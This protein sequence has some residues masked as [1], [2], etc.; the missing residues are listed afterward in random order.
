MLLDTTTTPELEA[1]GLARDVIRAVQDTRKA[2]GFDV[3]DRIRLRLLFQNADDGHAVQSA[4]EAADVAGETL[5][6]DARVLIAGELD[7]ADAGGVNTFSAVAARGH[8][9]NVAKGTYANRGSFM[10][11]VERIGGAA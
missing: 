8:G 1:E 3:S 5:A 11:V 10:V 7:P 4:F 9:V 6:V 2:A